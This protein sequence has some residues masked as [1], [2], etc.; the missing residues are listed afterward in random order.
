MKYNRYGNVVYSPITF[1]AKLNGV[2]FSEPHTS[3]KKWYLRVILDEESRSRVRDFEDKFQESE[4]VTLQPTI[5]NNVIIVKL[6]Y[7]Y[8]RFECRVF[9]KDGDP[10]TCYDVKENQN[11]NL[12]VVHAGFSYQDLSIL[13]TWKVKE[14]IVNEDITISS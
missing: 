14:I 4:N 2:V 8:N 13:S 10:L 9:D 3:C 6:P 1:E 12:L 7:R 5:T 11:V